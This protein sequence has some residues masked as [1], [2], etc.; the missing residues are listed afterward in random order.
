V[1]DLIA[2]LVIPTVVF[3]AGRGAASLADAPFSLGCCWCTAADSGS[4][5]IIPAAALVRGGVGGAL[6]PPDD[7]AAVAG[8][9]FVAP[10]N[11][12]ETRF[13][14]L[15]G[16]SGDEFS[17]PSVGAFV[18]CAAPELVLEVLGVVAL[19]PVFTTARWVDGE[20][21]V[22]TPMVLVP[23]VFVARSVLLAYWMYCWRRPAAECCTIE[24]EG[25]VVVDAPI[26]PPPPEEDPT[27]V[28]DN[29]VGLGPS[30][31]T[32][33]SLV[34]GSMMDAAVGA[35]TAVAAVVGVA[36]VVA[37]AE[38]AEGTTAVTAAVALG[39]AALTLSLG[40]VPV[41]AVVIVRLGRPEPLKL[42]LPTIVERPRT[43]GS[44]RGTIGTAGAIA[45]VT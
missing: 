41:G 9:L 15:G 29:T 12:T 38:A 40:I 17:S 14:A 32:G 36:K 25:D 20:G 3:A 2:A 30:L 23:G 28:E 7:N 8:V 18:V 19:T 43:P 31:L 34:I 26:P 11:A 22:N 5:L 37:A 6:V 16:R 24:D 39:T 13:E 10:R 4:M 35:G 27:C 21:A 1:D 45:A 44:T 42:V 33:L